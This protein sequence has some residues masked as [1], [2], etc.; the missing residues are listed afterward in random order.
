MTYDP[1]ANPE[2]AKYEKLG[3]EIT[4]ALTGAQQV[5]REEAAAAAA[6]PK[7]VICPYCG[8]QTEVSTRGKCQYC[9]G[10]VGDAV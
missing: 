5:V 9:G 4:E 7:I 1:H 10:F 8:A 2:Y 3:E 6:G